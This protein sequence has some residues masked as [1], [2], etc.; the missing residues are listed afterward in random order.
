MEECRIPLLTLVGLNPRLFLGFS[1]ME[2]V[3]TVLIL[4]FASVLNFAKLVALALVALALSSCYISGGDVFLI[5]PFPSLI[6]PLLV[7]PCSVT[8]AVS[9]DV[10]RI[11]RYVFSRTHTASS[12]HALPG[13]QWLQNG[14]DNK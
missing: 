1:S 2:D 4:T 9:Q 10:L 8:A 3:C 14:N 6:I 7:L 5:L 13:S 12:N 11:F